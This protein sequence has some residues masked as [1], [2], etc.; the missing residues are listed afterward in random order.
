MLKF[1]SPIDSLIMST[2]KWFSDGPVPGDGQGVGKPKQGKGGRDKCVCPKCGQ[3]DEHDRGTPCTEQKCS[4]CGVS[5]VPYVEMS[6]EDSNIIETLAGDYGDLTL[7]Y[8]SI[9]AAKAAGFPINISG[10]PLTISQINDLASYYDQAKAQKDVK[11]PM[12][13]AYTRFKSKYKKEGDKWVISDEYKKRQEKASEENKKFRYVSYIN[14][15]FVDDI[16]KLAEGKK[17][18]SEVQ[19]AK[20]G[21]WKHDNYGTIEF[22]NEVFSAF[23]KNFED[24]VRGVDIAIDEEHYPEKGAAGWVKKLYNKGKDGLWGLIEWTPVGIDLVKKK[25]F[26]YMSIE[27]D[28]DYKDLDSGNKFKWVL[29]GAALTNRPFLKGMEAVNLSEFRLN[30]IQEGGGGV[31]LLSGKALKELKEEIITEFN[32]KAKTD[33]E[34]REMSMK[35]GKERLE[36]LKALAKKGISFYSEEKYIEKLDEMSDEAYGKV[37]ETVKGLGE[38]GK[39]V[40]VLSEEEIKEEEPKKEEDKKEIKEEEPKKE[41][42]KKELSEISKQLKEQGEKLKTLSEENKKLKE[43]AEFKEIDGM[44]D[45]HWAD[46]KLTEAEKSEIAVILKEEAKSDSPRSFKLTEKNVEGKDKEV[47][48]T[49]K[50][51]YD[52]MLSKR[53]PMVELK[54]LAVEKRNQD[55]KGEHKDSE[56]EA[57]EI[58]D[59]A[60]RIAKQTTGKALSEENAKS[61]KD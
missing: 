59:N 2:N 35:K 57:Q 44:L 51:H 10:A 19:L 28:Q 27:Y 49:L 17:K 56:K 20:V 21:K 61:K 39:V 8:S 40:K 55:E 13:I 52:R 34:R 48:L 23:V 42:D 11:I 53:P 29:Y 36:E 58:K 26:K 4:K 37:K 3:V 16:E 54:E 41:E 43:T 33:K 31:F 1:L 15:E 5:M 50:E 25:I 45:K 22:N 46:G 60:A 9:A 38:A 47:S 30:E 18:S 32:E 6:E 12:A 7:P 14:P 24:N